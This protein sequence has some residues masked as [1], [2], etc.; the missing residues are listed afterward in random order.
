MTQAALASRSFQYNR[1]AV[2]EAAK[3]HGFDRM[4]LIECHRAIAMR[5]A[6]A[7]AMSC[8]S[9]D[10]EDLP[11]R[12]YYIIPL[13]TF[14]GATVSDEVE[15]AIVAI[16]DLAKEGLY[17][18]VLDIAHLLEFHAQFTQSYPADMEYVDWQ[19]QLTDISVELRAGIDLLSEGR[20]MYGTPLVEKAC[21]RLSKVFGYLWS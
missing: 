19:N 21:Q 18:G 15:E 1:D 20:D 11:V 4:E 14:T 6:R 13:L 17:A 5:A 16:A 7:F 12:A 9:H 3:A 2:V 8:E 10:M